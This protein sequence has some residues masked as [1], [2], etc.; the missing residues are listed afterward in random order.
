VS[1]R[2]ADGDHREPSGFFDADFFARAVGGADPS[3]KTVR[4]FNERVIHPI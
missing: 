2:F 3:G 4:T 1:E